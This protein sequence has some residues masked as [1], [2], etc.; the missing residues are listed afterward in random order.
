MKLLNAKESFNLYLSNEVILETTSV[1]DQNFSLGGSMYHDLD[2]GISFDF[3]VKKMGH[4]WQSLKMC[5]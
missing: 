3:L 2:L 1:I 4:I 5:F